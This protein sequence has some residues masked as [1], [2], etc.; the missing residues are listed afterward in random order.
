[1]EGD[2]TCWTVIHGAAA[3][4]RSDRDEFARR[5]GPVVRDYLAARW[6]NPLLRVHLDDAVQEFFVE[7]FRKGGVLSQADEARPAGFRAFLYGVVRNVALRI[8]TALA[9]RRRREGGAAEG[10]VDFDAVPSP[11]DT[12]S[13]VFDRAWATALVQAA[14]TIH[15]DRARDGG[16]DAMRRVDLLRLRF[17]EG[18]PI[19]DIARRWDAPAATLHHEYAKA[20]A[21]FREALRTVV[22]FDSAGPM[23]QIDGQIQTP[24]SVLGRA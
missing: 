23:P 4:S 8:E 6:R 22:A 12:L 21:E 13:V 11:E 14:A 9:K 20:R 17:F 5:Y 7:C 10:A 19:R 24:L 2:S 15:A 3:G 1:M 18:L 16:K